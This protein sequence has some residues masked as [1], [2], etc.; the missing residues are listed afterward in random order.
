MLNSWSFELPQ[1]I[2][3][4]ENLEKISNESPQI[5]DLIDAAPSR[6]HFLDDD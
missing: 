4:E 3:G 2:Q 1:Q 5:N 6:T